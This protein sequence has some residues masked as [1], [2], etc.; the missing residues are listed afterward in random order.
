MYVV[1][2]SWELG[3]CRDEFYDGINLDGISL[4]Y[5]FGRGCMV[6]ISSEFMGNGY[7]DVKDHGAEDLSFVFC[8]L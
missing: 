6:G 8:D 4:W 3:L 2:G 1:V 5:I 7:G